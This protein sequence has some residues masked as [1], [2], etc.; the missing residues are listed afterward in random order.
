MLVATSGALATT[1]TGCLGAGSANTDNPAQTG[2]PT[3]EEQSDR[4]VVVNNTGEVTGDP[5]LA[6]LNVGVEERGETASNVRNDL[7]TRS[8]ELRQALIEYG[9]DED[10][11]STDHYQISERLDR[12]R[13]EEDGVRPGSEDI[14]EYR[15]YQGTHTF[16]IE[17][18]DI[19]AVG[20][21]IDTAVESGADDVGRVTYTLS[22][23]LRSELRED[24]LRGAIE[25]ARDEAEAIADQVGASIVE[26][27]VINASDGSVTPVRR[28]LSAD[29]AATETAAP[30]PT[31]LQPGDVT[32]RATVRIEYEME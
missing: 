15:F 5:D 28:E 16:T 7:S 30:E 25:G 8:E 31:R 26:A 1:L 10:A 32:V 21:V 19:N 14:D 29:A 20:E 2:T 6:I 23:E 9:L 11:I 12:Q 17:I 3:I 24:A 13:M 18:G 22:D 4:R 27:T